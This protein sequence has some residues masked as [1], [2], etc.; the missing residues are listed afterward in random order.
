MYVEIAHNLAIGILMRRSS[1]KPIEVIILD[2][3]HPGQSS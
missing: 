3:S 1:W 2:G